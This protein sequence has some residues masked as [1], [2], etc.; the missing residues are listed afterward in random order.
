MNRDAFTADA[1]GELVSIRLPSRR[2]G[3]PWEEDWS[4]IPHPLPP[5]WEFPAQ[6][7]PLLAAAKERVG[8]L[9]G[10]SRLLPDPTV[11]LRPLVAREA[12][13]SSKIEGTHVTPRELLLF[14]LEGGPDD[15]DDA[16]EGESERRNARRE[17]ANLAGVLRVAAE[18]GG[19]PLGLAD[20]RG[21]H[22]ALMA[23]VRGSDRHPGRFRT[24]QVSLG[25][26]R[27]FIPPPPERLS[28]CLDAFGAYLTMSPR[29][30]DPLV[31]AFLVHYQFEAIHPFE[32]GNGRIGRLLLALCFVQWGALTR[33]CLYLSP[34]FE[35]F[36]Q[37]YYDRLLAVSAR[38]DWGGWIEYCLS[39][40]V[41][42]ADDTVRRCERLLAVRAD[43]TR[44]V[45][46]ANGGARLV[47]V[48]D[49]LFESPFVRV[50]GLAD[51]HGVHYNTALGDCRRLVDLGILEEVADLKPRTFRS[52]DL[53]HIAYDLTEPDGLVYTGT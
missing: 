8:V 41:E 4:F 11:L 34:Y 28:D 15:P 25:R 36:Q 38:G 45:A 3:G 24:V 16:V 49:G 20:L 31:D 33:P 19:R 2:P 35:R 42:S 37:E 44:R 27:K 40:V 52:P 51:R 18:R 30:Q 23:G 32:D 47:A 46:A 53:F 1:P 39:G 17:T 43:F 12:V 9:E 6:L 22:A 14:E 48:V 5:D 10:L 13:L 26:D 29:F 7:W 21:M 50:A